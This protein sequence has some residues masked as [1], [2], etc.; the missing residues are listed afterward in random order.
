[1][2]EWIVG[3]LIGLLFILGLVDYGKRPHSEL[4]PDRNWLVLTVEQCKIMDFEG[5][6]TVIADGTKVGD[7]IYGQRLLVS[8]AKDSRSVT[9]DDWRTKTAVLA[10][11]DHDQWHVTSVPYEEAREEAQR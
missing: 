2:K 5:K 10:T 3:S 4:S 7:T 9:V 11:L 6:T 8:W 1:V